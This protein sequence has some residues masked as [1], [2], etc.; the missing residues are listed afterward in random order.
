[1]FGEFECF[2]DFIDENEG[3]F[4]FL[5]GEGFRK[6]SL[7]EMIDHREDLSL[8]FIEEMRSLLFADSECSFS[9]SS[10]NSRFAVS[11]ILVSDIFS[12]YTKAV[13]SKSLKG[14]M[15]IDCF[16]EITKILSWYWGLVT[17]R[18]F[19]NERFSYF[20]SFEFNALNDPKEEIRRIERALNVRREVL[21]MKGWKEVL[22][23]FSFESVK[24]SPATCYK[25]WIEA[26]FCYVL[27]GRDIPADKREILLVF[28]GNVINDKKSTEY[29]RRQL[30]EKLIDASLT[31]KPL[32]SVHR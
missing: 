29:N 25:M 27:K 9:T 23:R 18:L 16:L 22:D 12:Y 3:L 8:Q 20:V 21:K 6:K 24:L 15:S 17:E 1:M 28:S 5:Y 19:N 2:D 14:C 32:A 31:M 30:A 10:A 11:F 4:V 7:R 26:Y 13:S